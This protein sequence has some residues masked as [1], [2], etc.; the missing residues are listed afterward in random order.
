M[1]V[2]KILAFLHASASHSITIVRD[3]KQGELG[4][5][6]MLGPNILQVLHERLKSVSVRRFF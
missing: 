2:E 3:R 1:L 4:L 6:P 5:E